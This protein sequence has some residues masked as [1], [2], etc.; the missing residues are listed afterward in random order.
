VKWEFTPVAVPD[1]LKKLVFTWRATSRSSW[2]WPGR[3]PGRAR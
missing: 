1:E 3:A 2:R